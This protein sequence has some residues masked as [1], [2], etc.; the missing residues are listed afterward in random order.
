[1]ALETLRLGELPLRG[2]L[3]K[4]LPLAPGVPSALPL[5]RPAAARSFSILVRQTHPLSLFRHHRGSEPA[6]PRLRPG[7]LA[8][9]KEGAATPP[10]E[11]TAAGRASEKIE[12]AA[13]APGV[14]VRRV[15]PRPCALEPA[16]SMADLPLESGRGPG[17]ER[18][19]LRLAWLAGQL[20][21]A[22]WGEAPVP[23]G[24]PR[25]SLTLARPKLV[26]NGPAL[27]ATRSQFWGVHVP[28]LTFRTLRPRVW[29]GHH[30]GLAQGSP[31]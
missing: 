8:P 31:G 27:A 4:L 14:P 17:R 25:A 7:D 2:A 20:A 23:A 24:A 19:P 6:T 11:A 10:P 1:M 5:P 16:R 3:T 18:G 26:R 13:P 9:L 22:D 29:V 15:V 30:P 21:P 28:R 12:I